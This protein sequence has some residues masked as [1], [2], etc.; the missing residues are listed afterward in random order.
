[1]H[2]LNKYNENTK[3][4]RRYVDLLQLEWV[5]RDDIVKLAHEISRLEKQNKKIEASY[6]QDKYPTKIVQF[7]S[8]INAN[9]I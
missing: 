1:M 7:Q 2:G 5:Q 9:K 8:K 4:L 3:M 6:Y